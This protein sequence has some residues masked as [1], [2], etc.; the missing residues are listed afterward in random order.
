MDFKIVNKTNETIVKDGCIDGEQFNIEGCKGCDIFLL[1]HMDSSFVDECEG[2]RLF[3]GPA[4]SSL[5]VRNCRGCS[6]IAACRQFRARDCED[7]RLGLFCT[8]EP[9]IETSARLQFACFDFCYFGLR[10]QMNHAGL[11]LWN[12]KWWQIFDFSQRQDPMNRNWSLLP[13]E[14]VPKLLRAAECGSIPKEELAMDRVV[15]VTL[16]CRPRPHDESCFVL[17]L[18]QTEAL[19]EAFLATAGREG[20]VLCRTRSMVLAA[21]RAKSLFLWAKPAGALANRCS[22]SRQEVT[23]VEVCAP[24]I[25]AEVSKVLSTTGFAAASKSIYIVPEQEGPALANAFFEVWKDEI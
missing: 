14:D 9:V 5:F 8:T 13:Q 3:I 23:G 7:L 21:D 20:W 2:C 22:S 6:I 16:G 24:Q 1:D 25:R 4:S 18:P 15:P 12:N 19:V 17:F 11:K 10:E